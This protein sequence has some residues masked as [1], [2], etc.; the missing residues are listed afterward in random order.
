[1]VA[2]ALDY[3]IEADG[4]DITRLLQE[5]TAQI[6]ITDEAGYASDKLSISLSDSGLVLP[7][8]G[9]KL[10][11]YAGYRNDLRWMG[12]YFVDEVT[13]S[14]APDKMVISAC[15]APF[16]KKSE[17]VAHIQTQ[18]SRSFPAGTIEDLV[19]TIAHEHF[20]T[21]KVA[22]SL[23]SVQ[24]AHIN[25]IDE[26]DMNLLTRIA[27]DHDAIAKANG[28]ALLFVERGEGKNTKDEDMPVVTLNKSEVSSGSAKL[29]QRNAF[30]KV[31]ATYRDTLN[32]R[33]VEVVAGEGEPVFRIKGMFATQEDAA[34]AVNKRLKALSR[35]KS[36]LSL[37][38]PFNPELVAESRVNLQRFRTGIDRVWSV[39]R[40]THTISTAGGTT[41]IE[42][43]VPV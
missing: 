31:A 13:L 5:H 7:G 4:H 23:A 2:C 27:F 9:T 30:K 32:S 10:N 6:T 14:F 17:G 40:A 20:L 22:S 38:L 39:T 18:K 42:C 1:M 43:E 15:G 26:S 25:Q 19:T 28:G 34:K 37:K 33:D 35:G 11:V 12:S 29:S 8:T 24:L 41:S 3:R 16:E 36:T 21:P